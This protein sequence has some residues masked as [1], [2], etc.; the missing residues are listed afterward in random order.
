MLGTKALS[1][2]EDKS[3][4]GPATAAETRA[5][6]SHTNQD[7]FTEVAG[8]EVDKELGQ[9]QREMAPSRTE[10]KMSTMQ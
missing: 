8:L 3:T 2:K 6:V 7:L 10:Q 1:S 9:R 5:E 4:G